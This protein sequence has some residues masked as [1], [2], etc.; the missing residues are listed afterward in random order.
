M[1]LKSVGDGVTDPQLTRLRIYYTADTDL[2]N[3]C[4]KGIAQNDVRLLQS[5]FN[6]N[7]IA[8]GKDFGVLRFINV[9]GENL[10]PT[11]SFQSSWEQNTPLDYR[12]WTGNLHWRALAN[13]TKNAVT[14]SSGGEYT[15]TDP[16]FSLPDMA[17][18]IAPLSQ[19]IPIPTAQ[20]NT[21]TPS[22]ACSGTPLT[23]VISFATVP[24]QAMTGMILWDHPPHGNDPLAPTA[25]IVSVD[26][27]RNTITVG[28][29]VKTGVTC[30]PILGKQ[31]VNT[32]DTIYFSPMLNVN[33][34]GYVP[35]ASASGGGL[36]RTLFS[37]YSTTFVYDADLHVFLTANGRNNNGI[38]AGWPPLVMIAYANAIGAHPYYNI[39]CFAMHGDTDYLPKLIQLNKQYLAP[40]LIP[41]FE[42]TDEVWN[43]GYSCT[44]YAST[45]QY[46]R[47]GKVWQQDEWY[48]EEISN[49]AKI[50]SAAYGNPSA[51][52]RFK[53]YRVIDAFSAYDSGCEPKA[54]NAFAGTC[55]DAKLSYSD[56]GNDPAYKWV[57]DAAVASYYGPSDA[58]GPSQISLAYAYSVSPSASLIAKFLDSFNDPSGHNFNLYKAQHELYPNFSAYLSQYV[59]AG[60]PI[61][62]TQYEGGADIGSVANKLEASV[63]E[64]KTGLITTLTVG[65]NAWNDICNTYNLCRS[66]QPTTALSGICRELDGQ[67]PASRCGDSNHDH[68]QDR[69]R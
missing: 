7:L 50:V 61:R 49:V 42:G 37:P 29:R 46:W 47:T 4:Y 69:D 41:F 15:L 22:S 64:V 68:R 2:V 36:S 38:I 18:V 21:P 51:T 62:F 59:K 30:S 5:C 3:A 54:T 26:H 12:Y 17:T 10:S 58:R 8:A 44:F 34:T 63:T 66:G 39:P 14:L 60:Y 20:P 48:G 45:K 27:V 33:G 57:T 53:Y 32:S 16:T 6:P 56:D 24:P 31:S 13:Y 9:M 40:G 52:D 55:Q 1:Q 19:D 67:D 11:N 28:C 65:P 35:M 25:Y 23:C 43:Y